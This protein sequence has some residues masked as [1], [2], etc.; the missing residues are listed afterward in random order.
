MKVRSSKPLSKAPGADEESNA[1]NCLIQNP[2]TRKCN[3]DNVYKN[4]AVVENEVMEHVDSIEV[5][6]DAND[7]IFENYI[8]ESESDFSKSDGDSSVSDY[9]A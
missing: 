1:D 3:P 6:I 4:A 9:A 2:K 7:T 5:L 8:T